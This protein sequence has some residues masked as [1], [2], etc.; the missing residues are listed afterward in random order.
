M[1]TDVAA[2]RSVAFCLYNRAK[3]RL[4]TS[5]IDVSAIV[6]SR[7]K[8][9]GIISHQQSARKSVEPWSVGIDG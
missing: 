1:A 6:I 2:V 4:S 7:V 3:F 8:F 5:L 9:N